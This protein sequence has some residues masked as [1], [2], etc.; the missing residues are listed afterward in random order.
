MFTSSSVNG[1]KQLKQYIQETRD[2]MNQIQGELRDDLDRPSTKVEFNPICR[3]EQNALAEKCVSEHRRLVC[4]L[5]GASNVCGSAVSGCAF[6]EREAQVDQCLQELEDLRKMLVN[7]KQEKNTDIHHIKGTIQEL[8]KVL[9]HAEFEEF[10]GGFVEVSSPENHA[11]IVK[12]RE[13]ITRRKQN[14]KTVRSQILKQASRRLDSLRTRYIVDFKTEAESIV[15]R[16]IQ[17]AEECREFIRSC[18]KHAL[19]EFAASEWWRATHSCRDYGNGKQ[20]MMVDD[21]TPSVTMREFT[22]NVTPLPQPLPKWTTMAGTM[23]GKRS[24]IEYSEF[25]VRRTVTKEGGLDERLE[26]IDLARYVVT[27]EFEDFILTQEAIEAFEW[28]EAKLWYQN[29][30]DQANNNAMEE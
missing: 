10:G 17:H 9:P 11:T 7:A 27:K 19:V 2:V 20:A 15:G 18:R 26:N 13:L 28:E 29:Q 1:A 16:I 14:Y 23:A 24:C 22:F 12:M 6:V 25:I 5:I 4:E 8:Y 21:E 3:P 30:V